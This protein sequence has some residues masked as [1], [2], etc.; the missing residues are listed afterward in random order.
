MLARVHL[1]ITMCHDSCNI[2]P[3]NKRTKTNVQ[4][5]HNPT[6]ASCSVQWSPCMNVCYYGGLG[7][8]SAVLMKVREQY[9]SPAEVIANECRGLTLFRYC[10]LHL[11]NF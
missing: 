1:D 11:F 7:V 3:G 8:S 2:D 4:P 6:P 9:V 10:F 5:S